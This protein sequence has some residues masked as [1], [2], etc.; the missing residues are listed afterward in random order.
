MEETSF[1]KKI[2]IG[3]LSIVLF[4]FGLLFS[5]K[6]PNGICYGDNLLNFFGFKSWT[7]GNTEGIHLTYIYSNIFYLISV[8]IGQKYKHNLFAKTGKILSIIFLILFVIFILFGYIYMD[9]V[10]INHITNH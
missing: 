8:V 5:A 1:K 10:T 3:S 6:F 9:S 4:I 7:V 2:G